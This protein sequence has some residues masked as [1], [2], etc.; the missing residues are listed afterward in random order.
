MR[1][2]AR[3][4]VFQLRR[5]VSITGAVISEEQ[6]ESEGTP[7]AIIE[8]KNIRVFSWFFNGSVTLRVQ[9]LRAPKKRCGE[10]PH[11]PFAPI[12]TFALAIHTA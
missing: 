4:T 9:A 8:L 10:E 12:N 5:I 7:V 3:G 2:G 6:G 1:F 11:K